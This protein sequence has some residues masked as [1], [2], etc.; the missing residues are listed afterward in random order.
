MSDLNN[1]KYHKVP[2]RDKFL[3]IDHDRYTRY[4]ETPTY[5]IKIDDLV[6]SEVD[7]MENFTTLFYY[8]FHLFKA[9]EPCTSGELG[10]SGATRLDEVVVVIRNES[11]APNIGAYLFDGK[12]IGE[13]KIIRL[14]KSGDS[15]KKASEAKFETCFLSYYAPFQELLILGFRAAKF[16]YT[17]TG[18]KQDGS[19][20]GQ[21]VLEHNM[22]TNK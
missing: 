16:K 4:V 21:N 11:S 9:Y 10:Q 15:H 8:D 1:L 12:T 6:K 5:M 20:K 14:K 3:Y 13:V 7:S 18:F 19:E 22:I 17:V 2:F